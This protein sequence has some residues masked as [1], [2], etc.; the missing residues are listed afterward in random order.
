MAHTIYQLKVSLEGT[1]PPIRRRILVSASLTLRQA[2]G[3]LQ[4]AMGWHGAMDY[5]YRLDGREF[6]RRQDESL[7]FEDAARGGGASPLKER[8]RLGKAGFQ[9]LA[10]ATSPPLAPRAASSIPPRLL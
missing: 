8:K 6:G 9:V 3:V 10:H 5:C 4:K 7:Y 2:H 1:A